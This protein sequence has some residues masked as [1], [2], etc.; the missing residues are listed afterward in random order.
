M[1]GDIQKRTL[2]VVSDT[3]MI[4]DNGTVLV[5]E[6][7]LRE[8]SAIE[9]MFDNIVWLGAR[10]LQKKQSLKPVSSE[11]ITT[12]LLPCLS[13]SGIVN[14]FY[15][16]MAYP[17]M[18]FLILKYRKQAT[19]VHTR[20][21]AHPAFLTVLLSLFDKKRIYSHKYA[22]EWTSNDS[23]PFSYRVQRA[24]LRRIRKPNVRIVVSGRNDTNNANVYDLPNPCIYEAELQQMNVVG[25]EKDFTDK[26]QLLF[27]GN[28][29]PSKGILE[30]LDALKD[31]TLSQR[32]SVVHIVGG[33]KL[34]EEVKER[35]AGLTDMDWRVY[36]NISRD[37]LNQLYAKVHILVLPSSSESFPKVIAEAAAYG[38]VPVVTPLSAIAKQI[39]HGVNGYLLKDTSPRSIALGLNEAANND[40]LKTVSEKALDMSARYTY[41][42]FKISM[43]N[44]YEIPS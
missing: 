39:M 6:P 17:V 13:R 15:V 14:V 31:K 28:M 41:E 5:F 37:D 2:L 9:D 25:R 3:A 11:K 35:A 1:R 19:H 40:S 21:P 12:V 34:L 29:M 23:I 26:L 20:G 32:Y 44:I 24:I 38:C 42:R 4:N 43:K 8:L 18:L 30:L 7:V 36:G 16:L 33:G 27:V 10:T 22:G